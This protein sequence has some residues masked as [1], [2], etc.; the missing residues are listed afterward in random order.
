MK[1]ESD[2]TVLL[3]YTKAGDLGVREMSDYARFS[4]IDNT[5]NEA[6]DALSRP[7]A[8]ELPVAPPQFYAV[9]WHCGG[10]MF[11]AGNMLVVEKDRYNAL[12]TAAEQKIAQQAATI[13]QLQKEIQ[14]ARNFIVNFS[15]N[16][17]GGGDQPVQFLCSSYALVVNQ[18]KAVEAGLKSAE[19]TIE[20][21]RG[22]VER[23]ESDRQYHMNAINRLAKFLGFR[24]TSDDVI[25]QAAD[26]IKRFIR[27]REQAEARVNVLEAALERIEKWFGEFPPAKLDDVTPCSYGFAF[28]SN[29]ERDFMRNIARE[30]LKE[31]TK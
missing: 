8:A 7:V 30:A 11:Y 1:D 29:G 27:E 23:K 20:Q 17:I 5:L 2:T 10:E 22:E 21:L 6:A 3:D 26:I 12:R 24:G 4:G 9:K 13:E 16:Q 18:K 15:G 31:P 19:Q 25:E 28:G 14:L